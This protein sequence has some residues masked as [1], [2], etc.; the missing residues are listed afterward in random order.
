M[1]TSTNFT[2]SM[3]MILEGKPKLSASSKRE[4]RLTKSLNSSLFVGRSTEVLENLILIVLKSTHHSIFWCLLMCCRSLLRLMDLYLLRDKEELCN[5]ISSLRNK[6]KKKSA[7]QKTGN[8]SQMVTPKNSCKKRLMSSRKES[9]RN[10][11]SLK[12]QDTWR[13]YS[14]A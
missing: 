4:H 10:R 14:L 1:T 11:A 5:Q 12:S 8:P 7:N 3:E 6:F 9:R 2:K 13:T